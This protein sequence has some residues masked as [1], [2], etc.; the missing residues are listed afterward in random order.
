MFVFIITLRT[1][2]PY[3]TLRAA[4]RF[5]SLP[6][7]EQMKCS[8]IKLLTVCNLKKNVK[9]IPP[10]ITALLLLLLF[11]ASTYSTSLRWHKENRNEEI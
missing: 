11:C 5:Y 10:K 3:L 6:K 8:R 4:V 1:L 7:C 9:K 2:F